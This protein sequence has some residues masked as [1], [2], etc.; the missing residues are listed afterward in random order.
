M[1]IGLAKISSENES[2]DIESQDYGSENDLEKTQLN[3]TI[4]SVVGRNNDSNSKQTNQQD[5][6]S[7]YFVSIEIESAFI[8][9]IDD[10]VILEPL[11]VLQNFANLFQN[12][13]FMNK[14]LKRELAAFKKQRKS[15]VQP[16]KSSKKVQ[17]NIESK[18][19]NIVR[20][21]SLG[22]EHETDTPTRRGFSG[23]SQY[24]Y[25]QLTANAQVSERKIQEL[26]DEDNESSDQ[27]KN[28]NENDDLDPSYV[29]VKNLPAQFRVFSQILNCS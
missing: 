7:I 3:R 4:S 16:R 23:I 1:L 17:S 5:K 28:E 26:T 2:I 21:N 22:S 29:K 11:N 9:Y 6:D 12:E 14:V 19:K 18:R 10:P 13:I 25:K 8:S 15:I 27:N 24:D 20:E